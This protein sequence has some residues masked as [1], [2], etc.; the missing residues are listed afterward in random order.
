[1]RQSD[2]IYAV[3]E[4]SNPNHILAAPNKYYEGLYL[5]KPIIT[6]EGTI[7]GEK[8]IKYNTGFCIQETYSDLQN[9]FKTINRDMINERSINAFK[10]WEKS[11]STY[12]QTFLKSKYLAFLN[13]N[14][15]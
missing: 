1:M 10:L 14:K 2:L 5:G 6:T 11:Y 3:Y 7:V 15:S 12:T 13:D 9:L 4:K 8:T